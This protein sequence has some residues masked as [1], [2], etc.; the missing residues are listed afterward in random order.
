MRLFNPERNPVTWKKDWC[1]LKWPIFFCLHFHKLLFNL[2]MTVY[3]WLQIVKVFVH[4]RVLA[5]SVFPGLDPWAVCP[6]IQTKDSNTNWASESPG[7]HFKNTDF[8]AP[9]WSFWFSR[10]MTESR[11]LFPQFPWSPL[12]A[13]Q[14]LHT[15]YRSCGCCHHAGSCRAPGPDTTQGD[16]WPSRKGI[17]RYVACLPLERFTGTKGSDMSKIMTITNGYWPSAMCSTPDKVMYLYSSVFIRTIWGTYC[18]LCFKMSKSRY[19]EG[20]FLSQSCPTWN[21]NSAMWT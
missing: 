2:L 17:H 4:S 5:L 13:G 21:I 18:H 8:Q 9:P 10:S 6:A 7:K 19:R 11:S 14:G 3:A 15:T 12:E 16:P 1:A 20:C